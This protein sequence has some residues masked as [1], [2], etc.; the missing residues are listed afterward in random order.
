MNTTPQLL[1][2]QTTASPATPALWVASMRSEWGLIE[3][4]LRRTDGMRERAEKSL[5]KFPKE[6]REGYKYRLA[7]STC[8]GFFVDAIA[9][10][11]ARPFEKPVKFQGKLP[12]ELEGLFKDVNGESCSIEQFARAWLERAEAYGVAHVYVDYSLDRQVETL[13]EEQQSGA[14]PVFKLLPQD[15]VIDGEVNGAG[16]ITHLRIQDLRPRRVGYAVTYVAHVMEWNL[17]GDRYQ[18]KLHAQQPD[19]SWALSEDRQFSLEAIPLATINL[20]GSGR[21]Q[22]EPPLKTLAEIE[23]QHWRTQSDHSNTLSIVSAGGIFVAGINSEEHKRG[24]VL[25]A[26]AFNSASDPN[27]SATW[28]EPR[29]EALG[30][31]ATEIARLESRMRELGARPLTEQAGA[32]TAT[33]VDSGDKRARTV[34]QSWVQLAEAAI[35]DCFRYAALW[36]KVDLPEDFRIDLFSDWA[37]STAQDVHLRTLDGARARGDI[38]QLTYLAELQRRGVLNAAAKPEEIQAAAKAEMPE[39]MMPGIP[40][41]HDHEPGS[42]AGEGE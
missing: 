41:D 38:D 42:G 31:R 6:S 17:E 27:A 2:S 5:P 24:F 22:A 21:F 23:E 4:L 18:Y 14:R 25:G 9:G 13:A 8:H 7:N 28:L 26:A 10:L 20:T 11:A 19:G 33:E 37:A 30:H 1:G 15:A 36:R 40:D 16:Q 29:G 12:A 32:R 3:A 39:P 35:T 34:L